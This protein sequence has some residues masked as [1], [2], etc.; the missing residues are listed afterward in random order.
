MRYAVTLMDAF[1]LTRPLLL[2]PVWGFSAFG[3][4]RGLSE[5]E[6]VPVFALWTLQRSVPV[7]FWTAVFSLS[8]AAV[9]V[10]NQIADVN[11]DKENNGLPLLARG[12][13]SLKTAWTCGIA[14]ALFSILPPLFGRPLLSVFAV[15]AVLLGIV[16]SFRPA[17]LS[18]RCCLDFIANAAGYGII[19]F[20]VG[21]HLSGAPFSGHSFALSAMPYFLL[22]CAGSISSTLPDRDS[23]A[24]CGKKTTAVTLGVGRA[25]VLATLFIVASVIASVALH[26]L[27]SGFCAAC[28]IPFYVWHLA[29]PG[30]R[31][32]EATYKAGGL[33]CMIAA[34]ALQPV[35]ALAAGAVAV[36]T[37]LYF[38]Q[39][40]H[41]VYPSLVPVPYEK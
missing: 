22:M 31:G 35:M 3:W 19:A 37:R 32:M 12:K 8:V 14:C 39:R 6:H 4:Y 10:F 33:L 16:Y 18:G 41:V 21:W 29:R 7:F 27:V 13:V 36:M 30:R 28:A 40:H 26:D 5:G 20:G 23:D 17:R 2:V 15:M 24:K 9:Y 34:A 11:V 1:F 25:H 38:K